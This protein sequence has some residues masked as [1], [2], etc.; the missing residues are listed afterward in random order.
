MLQRVRKIFAHPIFPE[1]EDKTRKARYANVIAFA[2]LVIALAYE[3]ALRFFGYYTELSILDLILFGVAAICFIGLI[4][5]RRGYV[6][7]TS[8]LLV[9]LTWAASNGLAANGYGAKDASYI[10]NFA[11]ILMAGLLLGWQGSLVV[12]VLSIFSGLA[13]AYAE[14]SGLIGVVDYPVT[15]FVRDVAFVFVLSWVLLVLLI[16]GLERALKRSKM[17]LAELESANASLNTAQNDLKNRSAELLIAN[18][19]LENRTKKLHAIAMVTRTAAAIQDFDLLLASITSTISRQL[20]Y[21]HVGLFL[22]DEQKE[23]AILR[24]TNTDAGQK[25]LSQGYKVPLGQSGPLGLVTQTGRPQSRAV[26]SEDPVLLDILQLGETRSQLLLPLKSGEQV[27]GILDIQSG[28]EHAFS[29]DDISILSILAD[30]VAITIQNLL[31]YEQSQSALRQADATSQQISAQAWKAYEQ[32]I[33]TKGYRYDGIKSEPLK[34]PRPTNNGNNSLL[35]PIRLRGQTIG[36]F[37]LNPSDPSRG[38]TDDELVMIRATAERVALALEGARLVEEAQK[39]A[40][41]EAF[42]S[43]VSTKLSASF[44]LDSILRDTVQELGQTLKNSTVTFQLI[45]PSAPPI[46]PEPEKPNGHT[47]E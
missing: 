46:A 42:L 2:F 10:V 28:E 26:R 12:T 8:M 1:D 45:N 47:S 24:S 41:R 7:L 34:E 19:Q 25:L 16:N 5:L 15:F 20:D 32:A 33:R 23:F 13:L 4:L 38:W 37:R 35:V 3:V 43:D 44:Q 30:Q 31:L 18:Q 14:Q 17:N 29:E 40:T 21:Y 27:T 22:M 9:V 36:S 11:I 39:R 6:R